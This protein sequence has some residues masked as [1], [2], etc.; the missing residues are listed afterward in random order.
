MCP[1]YSPVQREAFL[2]QSLLF[3]SFAVRG[4]VFGF[5]RGHLRDA[6]C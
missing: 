1:A 3:L 6:T 5:T 4:I 2:A